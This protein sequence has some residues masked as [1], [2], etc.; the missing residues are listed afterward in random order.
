MS[1]SSHKTY[2]YSVAVANAAY[3]VSGRTGKKQ[4]ALNYNY[5]DKR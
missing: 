5:G 1:L 3:A 2:A 4:Y